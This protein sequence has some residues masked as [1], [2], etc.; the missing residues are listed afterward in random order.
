MSSS[1]LCTYYN[2]CGA[3][4]SPAGQNYTCTGDCS[5][6]TPLPSAPLH[7]TVPG[8]FCQTNGAA[9]RSE[10]VKSEDSKDGPVCLNSCQG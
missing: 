5:E 3:V 9:V 2:I 10:K 6:L 7:S 1:S 4:A 8:K